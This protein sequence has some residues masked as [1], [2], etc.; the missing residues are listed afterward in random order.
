MRR[1]SGEKEFCELK[2]NWEEEEEDEES[3]IKDLRQ[4]TFTSST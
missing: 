3:L 2:Q 4:S 1:S